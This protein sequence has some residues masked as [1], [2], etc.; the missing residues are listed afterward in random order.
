MNSKVKKLSSVLEIHSEKNWN[1]KILVVE[2][3]PDIAQSYVD[4]LKNDTPTI[5]P[6]SRFQTEKKEILG[7]LNNFDL[8]IVN[9]A[10]DALK[11]VQEM[12]SKG[13]SFAMGFF[14]VRLSHGMDGIELVKHIFSMDPNFYAVF[15]TAYQDRSIESINDYKEKKK[16]C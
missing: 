2:D 9:S 4:I 6:Q 7:S 1:R 11:K 3:E 13:E 12:K 5:R 14:D 15:V 10:E 8:T 16:I